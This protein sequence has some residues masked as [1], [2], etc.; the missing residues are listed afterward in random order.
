M[1]HN[2]AQ[3]GFRRNLSAAIALLLLVCAFAPRP[4]HAHSTTATIT[5]S[6]VTFYFEF[7]P[8]SGVNTIN[9]TVSIDGVQKVKTVYKFTGSM[10]SNNVTIAVPVGTHT[11]SV[12]ADWDSNGAKMEFNDSQTISCACAT[13]LPNMSTAIA[14]GSAYVLSAKVLGVQL[15]KTATASSAQ[16][17]PGTSSNYTG[18]KGVH[19]TGPIDVDVLSASS[20]NQVNSEGATNESIATAANVNLLNLVTA[21]ALR[22]DAR[23]L[24]T[25]TDARTSFAGS[26]I[27]GLNIAGTAINSIHPNM[28][29]PL[30]GGGTVTLLEE[31]ATASKS[32]GLAK[33][34]IAINLI[35]IRMGKDGGLGQT[36]I[37]VGHAEAHAHAPLAIEC[38]S[39]NGSVEA[40]AFAASFNSQGFKA[41]K[42]TIYANHITIPKIGGTKNVAGQTFQVVRNDGTPIGSGTVSE[43]VNGILNST[44]ARA[45]ANATI[46]S[47]CLFAK[48]PCDPA[49]GLWPTDGIAM[50]IA[51]AAA[52]SRA[53]GGTASSWTAGTSVA[54]LWINGQFHNPLNEAPNTVYVL[55]G[56]GTVTTNEQ[57]PYEGNN[58]TSDNGVTVNLLHIRT[59]PGGADI[60]ISSARTAAH[61][62]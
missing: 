20:S 42:N 1:A 37:I 40:E 28:V 15:A 45:E 55:P 41:F 8:P 10:S 13:Q 31:V 34:N 57:I 23:A 54:T 3:S 16:N 39:P 2:S 21:T 56:I 58:N 12:H 50:S 52:N 47:M 53:G 43:Q 44:T 29:V 48:T 4:A 6:Q 26:M 25:P 36:D 33:A 17:G 32:S 18:P 19:L 51:T 60:I 9:E 5:C 46:E 14:N 61:H 27:E 35:H 7:F 38:P 62:Q 30:P 49:F 24:A 11:V 59:I 22:A